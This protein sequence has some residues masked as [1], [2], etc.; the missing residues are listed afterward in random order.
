MYVCV[1]WHGGGPQ[2][3]TGNPIPCSPE[4]REPKGGLWCLWSLRCALWQNFIKQKLQ[5][6]H[7]FVAG[8]HFLDPKSRSG[9]TCSPCPS[10]AMVT[11]FQG[12]FVNQK[13]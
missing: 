8:C 7:N 9:R 12:K 11:H 3:V 6:T 5:G 10:G 13:L 2:R 1:S 4:Y